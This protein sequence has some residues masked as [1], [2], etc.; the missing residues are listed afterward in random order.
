MSAWIEMGLQH[1]PIKAEQ[2]ALYMSAWIEISPFPPFRFA[3]E[4][5]LYMSA[6]IEIFQMSLTVTPH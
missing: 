4:V 3:S 6:W 5:A 2:V 1:R